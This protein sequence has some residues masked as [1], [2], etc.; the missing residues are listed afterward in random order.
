MKSH[1]LC[2][3]L[4]ALVFLAFPTPECDAQVVVYKFDFHQEGPSINYGFLRRR[5]GSWPTPSA[6]R[7]PGR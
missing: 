6:D 1:P 3:S 7:L 2:L 4:I 5:L